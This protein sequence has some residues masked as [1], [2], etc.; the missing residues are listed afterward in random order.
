MP[1]PSSEPEWASGGSAVKTEPSSGKKGEGWVAG[2]KPPAPY[3]NWLLNLIWT[4]IVW[5]KARHTDQILQV[6]AMTGAPGQSGAAGDWDPHDNFKI[7]KTTVDASF[8]VIQIPLSRGD[9]VKSA[10]FRVKPANATNYLT[11]NFTVVDE[12]G[13]IIEQK[14]VTSTTG[15]AWEWVTATLDDETVLAAGYSVTCEF[16][17][18]GGGSTEVQASMVEVTYDHGVD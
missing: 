9:T 6:G 10:R 18:S 15:S 3:F 7:I 17:H 5:V 4:W 13:A 2:E 12:D 14:S 11:C 16:H 8:W 1:M